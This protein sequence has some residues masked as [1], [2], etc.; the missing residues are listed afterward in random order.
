MV[1]RNSFLQAP[2]HHLWVM[3]S[4]LTCENNSHIT[5]SPS[6]CFLLLLPVELVQKRWSWTRIQ[7]AESDHLAVLR[8]LYQAHGA[9]GNTSR[10]KASLYLSSA[11]CSFCPSSKGKMLLSTTVHAYT[12]PERGWNRTCA[13]ALVKTPTD[14]QRSA[15]FPGIQRA[16]QPEKKPSWPWKLWE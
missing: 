7:E 10:G 11:L 9:R 14:L 12:G 13:A 16:K 1:D 2:L 4:S 3:G 5:L 8:Q 15:D 6:L